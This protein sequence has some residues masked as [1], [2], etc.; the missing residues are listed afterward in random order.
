MYCDGNGTSAIE[1]RY[2][3]CV[4]TTTG[5]QRRDNWPTLPPTQDDG[6]EAYFGLPERQVR[7]IL[8]DLKQEKL[9]CD[10]DITERRAKKR[11]VRRRRRK[12]AASSMYGAEDFG[13]LQRYGPACPCS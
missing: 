4:R 11:G 8:H 12:T 6:L 13:M 5:D 3:R 9:V 2:H 10:E 7:R 1:K